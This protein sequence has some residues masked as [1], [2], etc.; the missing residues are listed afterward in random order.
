[1]WIDRMSPEVIEVKTVCEMFLNQLGRDINTMA[2]G[3]IAMKNLKKRNIPDGLPQYSDQYL[4]T[5]GEA[6]LHTLMKKRW[7]QNIL[8]TV[9]KGSQSRTPQELFDLVAYVQQLH[10]Q[11]THNI[12]GD[13][14]FYSYWYNML[15]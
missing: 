9:N 3:M 7:I 1:M 10:Q 15:E 12:L 13:C 11:L 14:S 2:A 8:I 6:Q 4:K 5:I